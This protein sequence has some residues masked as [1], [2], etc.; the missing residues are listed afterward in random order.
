M[1]IEIQ[2]AGSWPRELIFAL[3]WSFGLGLTCV[4]LLV[5]FA[6][7][8]FVDLPALFP[9]KRDHTF[10]AKLFSRGLVQG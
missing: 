6:S 1:V 4:I 3:L 5:R 2:F 8:V 10:L 7:L 9:R